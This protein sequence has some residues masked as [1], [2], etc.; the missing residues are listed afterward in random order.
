MKKILAFFLVFIFS[1]ISI[2]ADNISISGIDTDNM[3][4][5]GR[6]SLY[7]SITDD[8]G[9]PVKGFSSDSIEILESIDD[10]SYKEKGITQFS[11]GLNENKGINIQLLIDNSGSMY[12]TVEGKE[13]D[14]YE[15]T[16]IYS[17]ISAIR[18]LINSMQGSKDKVGVSFF[19]TYYREL[20]PV[21]SNRNLVTESLQMLE[22]PGKDESFTE[23][24]AAVY[25]A[26]TDI[27]INHGRKIVIVLSDG[28]NYPYSIVRKTDSPQFGSSLYSTEDM[29]NGLKLN[30]ATLYGI[31]FGSKRDLSLEQAVIETGGFL[32]EA[33]SE[34]A[35]S[36]IY[37]DIRDRVLSEYYL[38]F[39]TDTIYSDRKFVKAVLSDNKVESGTVYYFS[40]N[41]FGNPSNNFSWLFLLTIPLAL[42]L[43]ILLAFQK[44]SDPAEK[45][46]LEVT[47]FS[48]STQVF[49]LNSNKTVI[50]SSD[51]N[52]ITL[53]T[54][55]SG[56]KN[57]AT[58][59]FDEKK[60][61][62]TVVSDKNV[63]VN[64]NP[65]KTRI[66]EPGDV[67]TIDGATIVFNDKE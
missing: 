15:E 29:I 1:G 8:Q 34:E 63:M 48:G 18:T 64:N 57:E 38:E 51:D 30:S 59:I 13:T 23:L 17:A 21:S 28:E 6:I 32:Y 50:G 37:R 47:D 66:L 7:L 14:V 16:R 49:D 58:I 27:S 33:D 5:D 10:L 35:L 61:V 67:I 52:D 22:R 2:S 56:S 31:N 25:N 62:Y 46:G 36:K 9:I 26:A 39:K 40:G 4:F 24:N 65:V 60:S 45:A 19:N 54:G 42:A 43:L 3:I 44:L 12:E 41:L 11:E 20:V 53:V 55:G